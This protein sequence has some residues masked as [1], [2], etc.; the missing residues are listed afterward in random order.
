MPCLAEVVEGAF[1]SKRNDTNANFVYLR[2]IVV[3]WVYFNSES[4]DSR[5]GVSRKSIV[6]VERL[7]WL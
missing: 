3:V 5:F 2:Y 1:K 7:G 4:I 6:V